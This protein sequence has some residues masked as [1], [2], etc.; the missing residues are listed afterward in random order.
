MSFKRRGSSPEP[1]LIDSILRKYIAGMPI[2]VVQAPRVSAMARKRLRQGATD[3][4]IGAAM[5]AFFRILS[6]LPAAA[7]RR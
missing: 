1:R 5:V 6:S 3:D 2:S 7:D 4:E